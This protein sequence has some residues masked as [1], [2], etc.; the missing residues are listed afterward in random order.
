M[1]T[2]S[3]LQRAAQDAARG[4]LGKARYRP[5]GLLR[6]YPGDVTLCA[7]L[8]KLYWDMKQPGMAGRY[9]YLCDSKTED[10]QIAVA[11]FEKECGGDPWIILKRLKLPIDPLEMKEGFAKTQVLQLLEDCQKKHKRTPRFPN[12]RTP[13]KPGAKKKKKRGQFM[14]ALALL[15]CGGL[16]FI[17][18]FVFVIG[19]IT[20][21]AWL[22]H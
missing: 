1:S 2:A 10:M 14:D 16:V 7:A 19:M 8:A 18:M 20:I 12:E 4:D 22:M 6:T 3:T 17:L 21:T 13:N 11:T 5:H 15:G 9:W